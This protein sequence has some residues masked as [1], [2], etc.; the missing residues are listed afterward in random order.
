MSLNRKTETQTIKLTFET[1]HPNPNRITCPGKETH[2]KLPPTPTGRLKFIQ[3]IKNPTERLAP[4]RRLM[5][6]KSKKQRKALGPRT[7]VGSDGIEKSKNTYSVVL[8]HTHTRTCAHAPASGDCFL[9]FL[10]QIQPQPEPTWA[11]WAQSP[12]RR[13][14]TQTGNQKPSSKTCSRKKAH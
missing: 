1:I 5:K 3:D 10:F 8:W 12:N 9:L 14:E 11:E 4:E 6:N 2:Y 7:W 13:T